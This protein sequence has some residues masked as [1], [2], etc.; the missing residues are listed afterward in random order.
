MLLKT[1][2][3]LFF[4]AALLVAGVSMIVLWRSSSVERYPQA[5]R[6]E[7][8]ESGTQI[9]GPIPLPAPG[10]PEPER[11]GGLPFPAANTPLFGP[12]VNAPV[13]LP[14]SPPGAMSD[15][16]RLPPPGF[17]M[18]KSLR[19][20][21]DIVTPD[22]SEPLPERL[23]RG[24][25]KA[26]NAAYVRIFKREGILE[27][28]LRKGKGAD[29]RFTLFYTYPICYFSGLPG[30][31]QRKG[32]Y[33]SPE[34]FYAV[35]EKQ[36]NPASNYHRAFNVG[37]PNAYDRRLKR[38]GSDLMVH[39]GCVSAG[40]Y[41]MTDRNIAEIY[42]LVEAALKAGQKETPVHIF[43]FRMTDEAMKAE[44][45]SEWFN[46]WANLKDGH[47]RFE[48]SGKPPVSYVCKD[49]YVFDPQ[50]NALGGCARIAGW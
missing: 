49:R 15:V 20:R 25:F 35:S 14:V 6:M 22:I 29:E 39:G 1:V 24:G 23:R 45:S 43:P 10:V 41:A 36:L 33:Q 44:F 30:P 17:E 26:G 5:G 46:F 37:Y 47:D 31:K 19:Q 48:A 12:P 21:P 34:G 16:V 42:G 28:W 27:L 9:S 13:L 38:T 40:C 7:K 18:P 50:K 4:A 2:I 32:D 8:L 3:R 11:Q